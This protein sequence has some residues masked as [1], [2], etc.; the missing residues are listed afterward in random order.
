MMRKRTDKPTRIVEVAINSIGF[1]GVAIG[2]VDG[3]V[4]FVKGALPGELVRAR[5]LRTKKRYVECELIEVLAASEHRLQ[6]PCPY[7][8]DCG[9]C[10][11]Q[12]L[13][14]QQQTLWKQHHVADAFRRIGNME[15][16]KVENCIAC[17]LPYG[18][19][20]KMEFSFGA[21]RWLTVQEIA[22][23][24][25]FDTSFAL[26]L[27]VPGRFDKVKDI[28]QC[29]LQ[30]DEANSLL[31]NV[32]ALAGRFLVTAHNQRT[33]EGFLRNLVVRTSYTSAGLMVAL[34]TTTPTHEYEIDFVR[35]WMNIFDVLPDGSTV[36]H[37][38]NDTRSPVA[39]GNIAAQRGVGFLTEQVRDIEYRISPFSFFQTNSIQLSYLVAEALN[40]ASIQPADVV[41]DLYCG[42]GTLTLPAAK[43]AAHAI[44][45]EVAESSVTDAIVNRDI[46]SIRNAEFR[47]MDLHAK[48]AME[49]LIELGKPNVV[50]VDPP[51]S[52]IHP[53]VIGHLLAIQP[54]RIAYVSCNPSTLARDCALLG[55]SYAIER[56]VP[57]DMFP[58]TFHIEAVTKLVLR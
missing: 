21:S 32:R 37:V 55:Q 50:V 22:T 54:E 58:Q 41:W 33:H 57:V 17:A 34:I 12:H 28:E 11:W 38:V 9:G 23:G 30:S 47:V 20:N 1:E 39:N 7:F 19:R 43:E 36:V 13:D 10:S 5:V 42:T 31:L 8:G 46:N 4:H 18:Y 3:I 14:Y 56:V 52:G 51:R 49:L 48:Q 26:G 45:F 16:V 35:E 2:R 40:A 44:G 6:A 29:L 24:E 53:Q 15:D 25:E 27:H